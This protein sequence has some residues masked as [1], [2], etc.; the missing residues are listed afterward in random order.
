MNATTFPLTWMYLPAKKNSSLLLTKLL[1]SVWRCCLLFRRQ[2]RSRKPIRVDI[3]N[4]EEIMARLHP[5]L[6]LPGPDDAIRLRFESLDDFLPDAIYAN[7]AAISGTQPAPRAFI[8][9]AQHAPAAAA[10]FRARYGG[11]RTRLG[12]PPR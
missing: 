11:V 5:Q 3:E 10:V 12:Q 8:G 6:E 4:F 2:N 1:L 7:R 9:S